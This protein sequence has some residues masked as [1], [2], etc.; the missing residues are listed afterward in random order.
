MAGARNI[1]PVAVIETTVNES[2][3][4]ASDVDMYKF[5]VRAGQR[6]G[7]DIDTPTNG[8]PGLGSYLRLFDS[9]GRQLAS[10]ND[11]VAPGDPPP[12][13]DA[14]RDGFDSY[15]DFRFATSGTYFIGVSNWRNTS[16]SPSTGVGSVD[17]SQRWLTGSYKL[18]VAQIPGTVA[19][20]ASPG[21]EM[22]GR[23]PAGLHGDVTTFTVRLTGTAGRAMANQTVALSERC[24]RHQPTGTAGG[25]REV[26]TAT[27]NAD[28]RAMFRYRI[29]TSV[30]ADNVSLAA[31]FRRDVAVAR[32][33]L[34]VPHVDIG[35]RA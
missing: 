22:I 26:G 6:V 28:G 34:T 11:R 1:G 2:I 15:I 19:S 14:G 33:T 18:V 24:A 12:G 13:P 32:A 30:D 23:T 35:R 5:T 25:V 20:L 7:F 27:T 10:N 17:T 9:R 31:S 21:I 3:R 16:Y 29:P 8:P 4:S